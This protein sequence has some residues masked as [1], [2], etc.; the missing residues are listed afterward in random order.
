[1]FNIIIF[2]HLGFLVGL[3]DESI[4]LTDAPT[5]GRDDTDT[6][7]HPFHLAKGQIPGLFETK[8]LF[9]LA[10]Q[11][12]SRHYAVWHWVNL[13]NSNKNLLEFDQAG[14]SD[15]EKTK[16]VFTEGV[17]PGLCSKVVLLFP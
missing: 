10:R 8:H 15:S 2:C 17:Q 12:K 16:C 7:I 1:L 14:I 4:S 6:S 13:N 5:D 3:K 9:L 11:G